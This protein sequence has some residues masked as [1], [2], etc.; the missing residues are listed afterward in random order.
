MTVPF[1][2]MYANHNDPYPLPCK[3]WISLTTPDYLKCSQGIYAVD[4]CGKLIWS[5]NWNETQTISIKH[6][7]D[8]NY[9]TIQTFEV[10]T[11]TEVRSNGEPFWDG[12]E[13]PTVFVSSINQY[14]FKCINLTSFFFNKSIFLSIDRSVKEF[15]SCLI[16][17][18]LF[19][20]DKMSLKEPTSI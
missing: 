6:K 14:T 18:S 20:A 5:R 8:N 12:V 13:L 15:H 10:H 2:C 3:H 7:N 1:G 19:T 4:R 9:R 11:E 17:R 16:D